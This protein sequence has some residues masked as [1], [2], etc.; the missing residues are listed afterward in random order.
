MLQNLGS[1]AGSYPIIRAGGSTQN[2]AVYY[3]NQTEALIETFTNPG[4]D[5]PSAL[6]IGPAWL[7]SF[8]QFPNGT[9]YT[10]GLNFYNGSSGLDQTVLE[11]I[12]AIKAIGAALYTFEIGNEVDGK[13]SLVWAAAD[14]N[15]TSPGWP[16]GSRRPA[17]WTIQDYV[18]EWLAYSAAIDSNAMSAPTNEREGPFYQGC[19]FEAPRN[20]SNGTAW[21]VANALTD[22]IASNGRLRTVADHEV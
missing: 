11:A 13:P 1:I 22:G 10:Y 16:G 2:R 18:N 5:Q 12:P 20:L 14:T 19:A 17:N 15:P 21:N 9:Q 4:D 7:E 3:P 6:T 8:Q